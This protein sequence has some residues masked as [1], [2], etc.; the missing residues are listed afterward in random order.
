MA[1][2]PDGHLLGHREGPWE[3]FGGLRMNS[4]IQQARSAS[5]GRYG[6]PSSAGTSTSPAANKLAEVTVPHGLMAWLH[7]VRRF[8]C[9]GFYLFL[10]TMPA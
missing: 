10:R 8:S 1:G 2:R 7:V 4:L 5:R 9:G 3:V 6:A